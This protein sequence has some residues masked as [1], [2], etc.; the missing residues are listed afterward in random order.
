M[1]EEFIPKGYDNRVSREY[2][3]EILHMP[4]RAIRRE[5]EK[6]AE[7]G[8]LI[9]SYDGGYF[10]RESERDDPYIREYMARENNRF[11]TQSHKNRMLREAWA[12][13]HPEAK[14][15]KQIPGQMSFF[16]GAT[17]NG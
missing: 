1:I 12:R 9:V 4:D 5:I 3:H 10:Q 15:S 17:I 2:L 14:K 11:K 16:G 6:A 13:I 7:R 8:V